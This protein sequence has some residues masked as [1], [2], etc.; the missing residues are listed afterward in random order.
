[1]LI[2]IVTLI[3]PV[4][5]ILISLFWRIKPPKRDQN[6]FSYRSKL[7]EQSEETW[8]FAHKHLKRL[9]LRFG[10]ILTGIVFVLAYFLKESY[11]DFFVWVVAGEMLLFTG[12]VLLVE[13]LLKSNFDDEISN[14]EKDK[15]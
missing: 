13:A 11:A 10:V 8:Q 7:S 9:W 3:A 15:V 1:M 4:G 5:M 2:L 12:S 14:S 6:G